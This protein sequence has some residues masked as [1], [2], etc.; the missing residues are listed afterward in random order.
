MKKNLFVVL[1]IIGSLTMNGQV[2]DKSVLSE[3]LERI[4][5]NTI[6]KD[7]L[8]LIDCP[9]GYGV[10]KTW[11]YITDEQLKEDGIKKPP[12][13]VMVSSIKEFN[14]ITERLVTQKSYNTLT[15]GEIK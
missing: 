9:M 15:M 5:I 10:M 14:L 1:F 6:N 11:D 2:S 7:T 8:Y 4:G 13:F 3:K 12:I